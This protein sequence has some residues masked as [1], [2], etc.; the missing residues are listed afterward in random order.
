MNLF[1]HIDNLPI[2]QKKAYLLHK[3]IVLAFFCF[4]LVSGSLILNAGY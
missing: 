1:L 4:L 3:Y 2:K